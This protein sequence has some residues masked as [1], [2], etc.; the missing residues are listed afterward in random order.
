MIKLKRPIVILGMHR[1]GTSFTTSV[2]VKAGARVGP[3]PWEESKYN[4]YGN[5]ESKDISNLNERILNTFGSSWDNPSVCDSRESFFGSLRHKYEIIKIISKLS[6]EDLVAV[7]DPRMIFTLSFWEHFFEKPTY[8]A[9]FRNPFS[10]A[11][12]LVKRNPDK[13]NIDEGLR[14]WEKYN[15]ELL[16]FAKTNKLD[17]W[18]DFDRVNCSVPVFEKC[19]SEIGIKDAPRIVKETY[20][21]SDSASSAECKRELETRYLD[22]YDELRSSFQVSLEI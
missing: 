17:Y 14:L 10:V 11:K 8:I 13:H 2:F 12:S 1:S 3:N 4:P 20:V 22:I 16:N 6:S 5:F 9:C 7:K 19:F 18:I 15:L 21:S